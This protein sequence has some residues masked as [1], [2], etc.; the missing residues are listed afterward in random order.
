MADFLGF[1]DIDDPVSG[2]LDSLKIYDADPADAESAFLESMIFGFVDD[3]PFVPTP[4]NVGGF[5]EVDD[6]DRYLD[7][8]Y[9]FPEE[10]DAG[11]ITETLYYTIRVIS[12]FRVF[13]NV[14][15]IEKL[16]FGGAILQH[17]TTPFPMPANSEENNDLT[18]LKDGQPFQNSTANY[19][20]DVNVG[21]AFPV[22]IIGQRIIPFLYE[23][24]FDTVEENYQYETIIYEDHRGNEQR[25]SLAGDRSRIETAF[26]VWEDDIRA[27]RLRNDLRRYAAGVVGVPFFADA[28]HLTEDPQLQQTLKLDEELDFVYNL[29]HVA[30]FVLIKNLIDDRVHE[31]KT[32]TAIDEG[33]KEISTSS[34]VTNSYPPEI[35]IVYP[36]L[37]CFMEVPDVERPTENILRVKFRFKEYV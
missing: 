18:V 31:I 5:F 37:L 1:T 29:K 7:K 17:R 21:I 26:T 10:I 22:S 2:S 25:R 16:N 13:I 11:F 8:F 6:V 33:L 3:L 12:L 9:V 30:G 35:S 14:T 32:I 20:N 28:F 27:Q 23:P 19:Y 15:D 24:D 34:V 4:G 36:I